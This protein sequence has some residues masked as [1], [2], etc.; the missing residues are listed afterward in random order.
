[1]KRISRLF[2]LAFSLAILLAACG[3]GGGGSADQGGVVYTGIT[4]QAPLTAANANA[5]FSM[6]WNGGASSL[7]VSLSPAASKAA[8]PGERKSA[9]VVG[10]AR[11]LGER[12][13]RNAAPFRAGSANGMRATPVNETI[14]GA[15]S[16]TLVMT[17]SIDET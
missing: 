15:V 17:G 14:P 16:G 13:T 6:I 8:A 10:I 5:I 2:T 9:G 4:A 3:G 1:M 7:S 12:L 11:S